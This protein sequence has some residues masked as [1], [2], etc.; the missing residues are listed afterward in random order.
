MTSKKYL[1]NKKTSQQTIS[2]SPALKDWIQRYVKIQN[3]NNPEDE[4]YKSVSAFYNNVL[5][6]VMDIFSRGKTFNDFKQVADGK[7]KN[8][9]DKLSFKGI[10]PL[11][12]M[13][14]YLNRYSSIDFE[15]SP[16]LFLMFR[17]LYLGNIDVHDHS[18]FT[19]I[20]NRLKKYFMDNN[21]TKNIELEVST[22]K[23]FTGVLE[24]IGT[25]DNL[26][27]ENSKFNAAVAGVL[28]VKVTDFL[29]SRNTKYCRLDLEATDLFYV[30]KFNK[31]ELIKL[32]KH[33]LHY[34]TNYKRIINDKAHFLWLK[35]AEDGDVIVSFKNKKA[36]LKWLEIIERDLRT[37]DSDENFLLNLLKT[38]ERFHWISI[39]NDNENGLSF[40]LQLLE[41]NNSNEIGFLLESLSKHAKITSLDGIYNLT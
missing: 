39:E 2:I 9:F 38:F 41:K 33:N 17:K 14:V 22:G 8:F 1:S 19:D 31:K 26:T 4:R 27:Y 36:S 7:V 11:Y 34:F 16:R 40:R 10:I 29:Y 5:E 37:Y 21:L 30:K 24:Y 25:H 35:M 18:T 3:D 28:G 15:S 6:M 20:F 32:I 23:Y 13:W 12:E